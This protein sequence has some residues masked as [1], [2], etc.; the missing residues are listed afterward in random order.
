MVLE[1]RVIEFQK[2]VKVKHLAISKLIDEWNDVQFQIIGFAAE[3]LGPERVVIKKDKKH[4]EHFDF[5]K[6]FKQSKIS[7]DKTEKDFEVM[8]EEMSGLEQK[9]TDL[10]ESTK[11]TMR[12]QQQ[13]RA[14]GACLNGSNSNYQ[15]RALIQQRHLKEISR[16][17]KEM[18]FDED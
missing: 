8:L 6:I 10:T 11:E 7:H 12:K 14:T 17:A 3:I 15:E 18:E 16:L 2:L 1:E 5:E 13:V 4:R 9:T